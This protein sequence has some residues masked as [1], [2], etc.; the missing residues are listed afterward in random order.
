MRLFIETLGEVQVVYKSALFGV[1]LGVRVEGEVGGLGVDVD[2]ME[3][4]G[5]KE[6]AEEARGQ[7]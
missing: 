4:E 5:F 2:G 6:A 1:D 7:G 3:D